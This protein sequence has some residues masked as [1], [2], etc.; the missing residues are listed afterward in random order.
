M[1]FKSILISLHIQAY[2]SKYSRC[3]RWVLLPW[4]FFFLDKWKTPTVRRTSNPLASRNI[5]AAH[6][7]Y[8]PPIQTKISPINRQ[9]EYERQERCVNTRKNRR[10]DSTSLGIYFLFTPYD[11]ETN[12]RSLTDCNIYS[13]CYLRWKIYVVGTKNHKAPH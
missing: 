6:K 11:I 3:F 13:P 7:A 8:P 10:V 5:N 9:C 2:D 4:I 1:T 12:H